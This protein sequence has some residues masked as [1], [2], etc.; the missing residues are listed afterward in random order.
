[1]LGTYIGAQPFFNDAV[2]A[3]AVQVKA[4]P[5]QL[6]AL[7]LVNTTAAVAYLQIFDQLAAN[8]TVGTTAPK[9]VIRLAA[10]E[11]TP[12]PLIVP[13]GIGQLQAS[14]P[15]ISMAGTTTAGGSTPA[16]ISVSALFE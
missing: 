16:A 2:A 12:I 13:L 8:V 6:F 11:S 1:M 7:K 4:G 3:A 5:G 15:G 14:N 9:W 10:S